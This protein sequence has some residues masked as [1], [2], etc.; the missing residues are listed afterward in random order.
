MKLCVHVFGFCT[1]FV[2]ELSQD[3]EIYFLIQPCVPGGTD[4]TIPLCLLSLRG[5][6]Y[7]PVH[8]VALSL[9]AF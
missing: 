8:F 1:P 4:L 2:V 3:V 5:E 9:T 7:T 6:S